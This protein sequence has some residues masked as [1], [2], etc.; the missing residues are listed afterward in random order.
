ML[1]AI[2]SR[3]SSPTGVSLLR[4]RRA[5]QRPLSSTTPVRFPAPSLWTP[6]GRSFLSLMPASSRALEF[7][8]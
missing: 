2:P 3:C 7:A 6:P 8:Q 5:G 1:A 4:H